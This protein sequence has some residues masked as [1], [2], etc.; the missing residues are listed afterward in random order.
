M[1]TI[2]RTDSRVS[3]LFDTAAA[4]SALSNRWHGGQSSRLYRLGCISCRIGISW[5]MG[6]PLGELR[7]SWGALD[8]YRRFY[9]AARRSGDIRLSR[10][11]KGA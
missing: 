5:G 8:K 2:E 3:E 1:S 10:A 7:S 9:A 11:W 4:L 6:G